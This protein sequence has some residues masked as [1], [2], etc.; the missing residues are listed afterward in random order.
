M[1]NRGA[2]HP[3]DIKPSHHVRNNSAPRPSACS[4]TDQS[5]RG[6]PAPVAGHSFAG[7]SR[8]H[9]PG[10]RAGPNPSSCPHLS[11]VSLGLS[12]FIES[13]KLFISVPPSLGRG[14]CPLPNAVPQGCSQCGK[15]VVQPQGHLLGH[16]LSGLAGAVAAESPGQKEVPPYQYGRHTPDVPHGQHT[17]A[18]CHPE[19][20]G[21][22]PDRSAD[23]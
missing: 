22:R 16:L 18:P 21:E 6:F 10:E 5:G 19:I 11:D 4:R 1:G 15:A 2:L 9:R 8:P 7:A 3:G 23:S 17:A 13:H 14:G 12:N 20:C